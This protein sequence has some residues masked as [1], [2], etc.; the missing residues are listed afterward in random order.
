MK[1]TTPAKKKHVKNKTIIGLKFRK[2]T[3]FILEYFVKNKTIIG[4]K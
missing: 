3:E 4:L 2:C 1:H